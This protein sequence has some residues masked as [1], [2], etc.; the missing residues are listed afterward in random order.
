LRIEQF[1]F[2]I[3]I[4]F[5]GPLSTPIS[6]TYTLSQITQADNTTAIFYF[7]SPTQI[8]LLP[9]GDTNPAVVN[10]SQ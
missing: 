3:R 8:V 9:S 10:L 2:V 5:L 7:V 6:S 1:F 4:W